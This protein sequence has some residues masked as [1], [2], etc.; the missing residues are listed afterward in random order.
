MVLGSF[1]CFGVVI[2]L[3]PKDNKGKR[4][5]PDVT[6]ILELQ[7]QFSLMR[8]KHIG[9]WTKSKVNVLLS[10]PR[11]KVNVSLSLHKMFCCHSLRMKRK[12][13]LSIPISGEGVR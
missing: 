2:S 12:S 5:Q 6:Q 13:I 9:Q 4:R 11:S 3:T 7:P 10:L 8:G 1:Y